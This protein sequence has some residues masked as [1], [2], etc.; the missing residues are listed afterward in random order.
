MNIIKLD[1][2]VGKE[3]LATAF[4]SRLNSMTGDVVIHLNSEG[5]S[6]FEG[7]E[8]YNALKSYTKGKTTVILNA[9]V[10]SIASYFAM[11]ADEVQVYDNSTFMIH[12]AHTVSQGDYKSFMKTAEVLKGVTQ[13]MRIAYVAKSGKT[14][15]D[16]TSML[17]EE[18]YLFGEQIIE[19]GFADKVIESGTELAAIAAI[20]TAKEKIVSCANNCKSRF[21]TEINE[22]AALL[23]ENEEQKKLNDEA[24]KILKE[25]IQ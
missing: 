2:V 12:N 18:T 22:V 16:I 6:V 15:S 24:K 14:L 20:D 9:L 25:V 11:G 19:H 13:L 7:V 1:G 10:A 23:S 4:I 5:G 3:I 17:D 8:M 21:E